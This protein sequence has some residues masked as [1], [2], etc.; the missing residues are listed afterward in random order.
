MGEGGGGEEVERLGGFG[1]VGFGSGAGGVGV[2]GLGVRGGGI[3]VAAVEGLVVF[4]LETRFP[5]LGGSV[6]V[7]VVGGGSV[8]FLAVFGLADVEDE[9]FVFFR[10]VSLDEREAEAADRALEDVFYLTA[11]LGFVLFGPGHEVGD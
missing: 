6:D 9:L 2:C 1:Y 3:A 8:A 11:E 10:A 5:F 4:A 7:G